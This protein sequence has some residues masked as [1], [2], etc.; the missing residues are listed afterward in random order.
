MR[1][2]RG[3]RGGSVDAASRA[4]SPSVNWKME[5]ADAKSAATAFFDTTVK[6]DPVTRE[7]LQKDAQRWLGDLAQLSSK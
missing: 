4:G 7:W 1:G 2:R 3:T 6:G 5:L